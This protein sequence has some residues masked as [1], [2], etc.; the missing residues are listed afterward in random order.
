MS[1]INIQTIPVK[2]KWIAQRCPVCN[3][4]KTVGNAKKPCEVCE[5]LGYIKIPVEETDKKK[6]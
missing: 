6:E 2:P 5:A 1:D 4:W 3:G